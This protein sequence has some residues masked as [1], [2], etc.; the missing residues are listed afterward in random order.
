MVLAAHSNALPPPAIWTMVISYHHYWLELRIREMGGELIFSVAEWRNKG[1]MMSV[2]LPL[3]VQT[4]QSRG[5]VGEEF[6]DAMKDDA[7][8]INCARG[9]LLQY[10]P[11]MRVRTFPN[12]T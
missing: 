11:V 8:L 9:G 12:C 1:L 6:L 2:W 7:F 4:K 3:G 10:D 5:M